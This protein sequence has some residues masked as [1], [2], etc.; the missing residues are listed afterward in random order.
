[1]AHLA[2]NT[3]EIAIGSGGV[4]L[5]NHPPLVVAEQFAMLEA[6]HPGRIDLGIG[7]APGTDQRTMR[8]LRRGA[9]QETPEQFPQH[10]LDV[11]SMLGDNRRSDDDRLP[12][13]ATPVP[14]S[15]PRVFLLGSSTFSAQLAGQLGLPFSFAHHFSAENMHAAVDHYRAAF[16]PSHLLDEPYLIIATAAL[17]AKTEEEALRLSMPGRLMTVNIRRNL[18]KPIP[19]VE[20]ADAHADRSLAL[21]MTPDRISGSPEVVLAALS[22]LAGETG[23]DELMITTI[24]HGLDERLNS[25]ELLARAWDE[26]QVETV[27][28]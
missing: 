4:M 13:G 12:F 27:L 16:R 26:A 11:M 17:V 23:A 6:L 22:A 3:K 7:R 21:A 5:P 9:D 10:L 25:M 20:T 19:S 18:S 14:Q 8:A 1:M 24:T 28:R 2:A 15:S